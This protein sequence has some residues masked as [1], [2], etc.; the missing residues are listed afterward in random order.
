MIQADAFHAAYSNELGWLWSTLRRLG[1]PANALPDACHDVFVVA[2]ERRATFR[3]DHPLRPW[4]FGIACR[5]AANRRVRMAG[6][7]AL[8]DAPVLSHHESPEALLVAKQTL[9]RVTKA[10]DAL[11]DEKRQVLVGHDIEGFAMPELTQALAVPLNTAY[12][13]LRHA[14]VAF[15]RAFRSEESSA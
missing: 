2:W 14:R 7:E 11:D 8:T 5:L 4:L 9:D 12:S 3:P 13:R 6:S 1:V 15:E 10:L